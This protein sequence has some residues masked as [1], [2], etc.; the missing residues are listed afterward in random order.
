MDVASSELIVRQYIKPYLKDRPVAASEL[1]LGLFSVPQ[2][3]P[4]SALAVLAGILRDVES[5]ANAADRVDAVARDIAALP[6]LRPE[7][8][9]WQAAERLRRKTAGMANDSEV[10]VKLEERISLL[11]Q[12]ERG[13]SAKGAKLGARL[14]TPEAQGD[15]NPYLVIEV[16]NPSEVHPLRYLRADAAVVDTTERTVLEARSDGPVP[17]VPP[18]SRAEIMLWVSDPSSWPD[19]VRLRVRFSTATLQGT[20]TYEEATRENFALRRR[21]PEAVRMKK[22]DNP[23]AV[24][25][26]VQN[27][28]DIVGRK[29]EVGKI[30]RSLIGEKRD[31]V[32]VVLGERRMGKT[33]VL[34]AVEQDPDVKDRYKDRVVRI[35]V[36]DVPVAERAGDFFIHRLVEPTVRKLASVGMRA[37]VVREDLFQKSP[38]EAFKQFMFDLDASLGKHRAL[39]VIDELEKLLTVIDQQKEHTADS[40]G[41]EV[42]ASLRAV[43]MQVKNVSFILQRYVRNSAYG[44]RSRRRTHGSPA[45]PCAIRLPSLVRA[46]GEDGREHGDSHGRGACHRARHRPLRAGV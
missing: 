44:A 45:I 38:Y 19:N 34:N 42:M 7:D 15:E 6:G 18:E 4:A 17:V 28:A 12:K 1:A 36:Q 46:H 2:T 43:M 26:A 29:D 24:G 10:L 32:V 27:V 20:Q 35:D 40:L 14:L 33:T 8:R 9:W 5:L 11:Q 21:A 16:H 39:I 31:N 37:P 25:G 13:K 41:S 30:I 3:N 22:P 23:Y